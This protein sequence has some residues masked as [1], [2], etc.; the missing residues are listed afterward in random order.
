MAELIGGGTETLVVLRQTGSTP[1]T[2]TIIAI[3]VVIACA[4]ALLLIRR[5]AT[6]PA[7][8]FGEI[9]TAI[10]DPQQIAS[11]NILHLTQA[12][13][14]TG[15]DQNQM[16]RQSCRVRETIMYVY[17]IEESENGLVHTISS[18]LLRPKPEK[19]QLQCMLIA[20]LTLNQCLEETGIDQES[21]EFNNDRSATGTHYVAMLLPRQKHDQMMVNRIVAEQSGEPDPPMARDLKS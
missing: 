12:Q 13:K 15:I 5:G 9:R 2:P 14:V 19:Y 8:M 7:A 11:K 18:Q 17:T 4:L 1:L 6:P 20:M 3:S 10:L 21:V 16:L